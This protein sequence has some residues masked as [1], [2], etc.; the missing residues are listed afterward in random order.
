MK[1][2]E[3]L[4]QIEYAANKKAYS[5]TPLAD[6]YSLNKE[7]FEFIYKQAL[8]KEWT[9][10]ECYNAIKFLYT[11]IDGYINVLE[12]R[13]IKIFKIKYHV[14]FQKKEEFKLNK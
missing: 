7:L 4:T 2:A 12:K 1:I 5:L 9:L 10:E 8:T 3:K 6:T 14:L 11:Y 13:I